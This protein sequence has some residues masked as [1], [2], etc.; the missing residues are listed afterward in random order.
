VKRAVKFSSLIALLVL[1]MHCGPNARKSVHGAWG[2][3]S[4]LA[5]L[6][7]SRTGRV[8]LTHEDGTFTGKY[9]ALRKQ[10]IQVRSGLLGP[11]FIISRNISEDVLIIEEVLGGTATFRRLSKAEVAE[12]KNR[13]QAWEYQKDT[14]S[15]MSVLVSV[16]AQSAVDHK[17]YAVPGMGVDGTIDPEELAARLVPRYIRRFYYQDGWGNDY[18][19]FASSDGRQHRMVSAGS[20][21]KFEDASTEGFSGSTFP[22]ATSCY[23]S[24]IVYQNG[25]F[26]SHPEGPQ[27]FCN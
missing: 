16:W 9:R 1:S 22:G 17:G 4:P 8:V 11:S 25:A 19:F 7:L 5:L 23:E 26:V 15:H 10:R 21:G 27:D 12:Q 3:S 14:L 18:R 13:L 2:S 24:D 6:E 20:D